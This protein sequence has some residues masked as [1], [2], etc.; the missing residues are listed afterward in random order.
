MKVIPDSAQDYGVYFNHFISSTSFLITLCPCDPLGLLH[1]AYAS[2]DGLVATSE[3]PDISALWPCSSQVLE[4][5]L[6]DFCH[7]IHGSF[8]LTPRMDQGCHVS[9]DL[10]KLLV[11]VSVSWDTLAMM[12]QGILSASVN[13]GLLLIHGASK[14]LTYRRLI[15]ECRW[16][17]GLHVDIEK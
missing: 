4:W 2:R 16:W 10:M 8:T 17:N 12:P 15:M 7:L 1:T 13:N 3:M 5:G 6:L 9:S 11:S 14:G